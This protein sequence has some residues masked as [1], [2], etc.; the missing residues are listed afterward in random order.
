MFETTIE[1]TNGA[2]IGSVL[3]I[4]NGYP[5]EPLMG[6]RDAEELGFIMFNLTGKKKTIKKRHIKNDTTKITWKY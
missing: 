1:N 5:P 2:S 3:Y 4:M 6:Y